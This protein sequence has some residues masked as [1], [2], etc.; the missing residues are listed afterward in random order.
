M[1]AC[2]IT[3]SLGINGGCDL[4]VANSIGRP[5][6]GLPIIWILLPPTSG[7]SIRVIFMGCVILFCKPNSYFNTKSTTSVKK[8]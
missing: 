6:S 8:C 5:F 2:R 1:F 3:I 4:N 7:D